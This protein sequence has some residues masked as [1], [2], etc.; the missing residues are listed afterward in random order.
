MGDQVQEN[1]VESLVGHMISNTHPTAD[2]ETV[3][4]AICSLFFVQPT[5]WNEIVWVVEEQRVF[6]GLISRD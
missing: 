1:G 3:L 6:G 4:V 5:L 2:A